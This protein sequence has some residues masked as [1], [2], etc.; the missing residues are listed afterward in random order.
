[1]AEEK[2]YLESFPQISNATDSNYVPIL[3]DKLLSTRCEVFRGDHSF[4]CL[5]SIICRVYILSSSNVR[6]YSE[7][8]KRADNKV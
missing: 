5:D 6:D 1:M 4:Y 2:V 8:K 3:I 7:V